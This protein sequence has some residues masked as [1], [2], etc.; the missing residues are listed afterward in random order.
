MRGRLTAMIFFLASG[1][2]GVFFYKR[3]HIPPAVDIPAIAVTD[4]RGQPASLGAY[5]GRPL[6]VS[7]F[8][9]W[10][11]PCMK[12]LPDLAVLHDQ[13]SDRHLTVVC[14]SDDPV[15]KLQALDILYGGR[16]VF[17]HVQSLHDVGIYTYPT[18]Y[19]FNAAGSKIYSQVNAENWGSDVM[20]SKVRSMLLGH[21]D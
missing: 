15:E 2:V 20:I 14:I 18:N 17:L 1:L 9:T 5:S 7:F 3:Y 12:E 10:C 13:L 6:F 4:L 16:L 19:I 11:G 8:A 21:S